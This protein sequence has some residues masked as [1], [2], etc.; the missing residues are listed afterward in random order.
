[1]DAES[2]AGR[3]GSGG[4]SDRQHRYSRDEHNARDV[5]PAGFF[6]GEVVVGQQGEQQAAGDTGSE[7]AEGSPEETGQ[8]ARG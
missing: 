6:H 5:A 2:A 7:L 3:S 4:Q 1:M 8:P